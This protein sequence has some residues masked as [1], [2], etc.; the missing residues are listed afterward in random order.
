[1]NRVLASVIQDGL[2]IFAEEV[3]SRKPVT[4]PHLMF[5]GIGDPLCDN[6]PLQVT[7]FEAD[8]RIGDQLQKMW[9]ENGGGGNH[10]EGYA[11][12][13]YFAAFH[14]SIDSL[15]KREKKGFLFTIG[16]DG[17]TTKVSKEQIKKLFGDTVEK[18]YTSAELLAIVS[19]KY[20]VFH[21]MLTGGSHTPAVVS[22]W[23]ALLGERAIVLTNHSKIGEVIVSLLQVL[24][25]VEKE[26]VVASWD[27]TTSVVVNQAIKN[28]SS[29]IDASSSL[30]TF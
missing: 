12:A 19:R 3:Y 9:L 28:I 5:M 14:T 29:T 24:S 7:Q 25:G 21:L 15:E 26:E 13:W 6:S 8:I 27:G 23:R 2:P 1:M 11:L 16:D 10:E 20:E 30:V 18:D 4:D 22:S 17:P